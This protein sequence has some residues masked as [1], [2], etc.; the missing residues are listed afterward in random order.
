V[1]TFASYMMLY[2]DRWAHDGIEAVTNRYL[3]RVDPPLLRGVRRIEGD[4]MVE[5]TPSG[6]RRF[7]PLSEAGRDR[8]ARH[9]GAEAVTR[10][11]RTIRLD[12]SD[13]RGLRPAAEP[14]EWAVPGTFLFWGQA[15]ESLA[16]SSDRLPLGLSGGGS[17]GHS[18]LVVVQEATMAERARRWSRRWRPRAGR[19]SGRARH[20]HRR[21]AAEEE[22]ALAESLCR[23][24][25]PN[26]LIA[27]H[28]Q[29]EGG[30]IREQFRT[31]RPRDETAFDA[32][33]LQGHDRAFQF[34]EP[35]K[36][37]RGV[38]LIALRGGAMPEFWVASGHHLTRLDARGRMLVTDELLLA[39]LARP[40]VLPPPE[41]CAAER[42]LHA[43][44][45]AAPRAPVSHL[46]LAALADPDAR[47][48]WTFLPDPAR[49]G[50]CA[51]ARSRVAIFRSCARGAACRWCFSTSWCS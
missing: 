8:L 41:A 29:Q 10:L 7:P 34:V 31:L 20:R 23:D 2:F 15:P 17:F 22:V 39:W 11:P 12:A 33:Y 24:H 4:R 27:L 45:M 21:P 5:I 30:E 32:P 40:E 25:A 48:N 3:M 49:H 6:N 36:G 38:D 26:T 46:E 14:G 1:S 9:G 50:C 35:T 37:T 47:E 13:R 16:A 28:R 18:T 51:P 42:A 43:R 19:P 44:L